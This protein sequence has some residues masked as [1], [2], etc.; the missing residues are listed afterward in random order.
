MS[1]LNGISDVLFGNKFL[2]PGYQRSYS[3][4]VSTE[5][6]EK[7][8]NQ[9]LAD[10]KDF[11]KD[12]KL[13]NYYF[14]HFILKKQENGRFDIVDGQQRLTTITIFLSAALERVK[15]FDLSNGIYGSL[16]DRKF[17]FKLSTV[18]YDDQL[19]QDYV[20]EGRKEAKNSVKTLSQK[21]IVE[22]YDFFLKE[23]QR[24]SDGDVHQLV[25]AV[26][27]ADC[28]S[29]IVENEA[30]AMRMFVFENNRGKKLT[31]LD[32]LKSKL[33]IRISD[34][35][36]LSECEKEDWFKIIIQRFEN[37]YRSLSKFEDYLDED[38]VL[39]YSLNI[40]F[41]KFSATLDNLYKELQGENGVD[42]VREFTTRLQFCCDILEKFFEE[43][44]TN[45]NLQYVIKLSNEDNVL[46][47]FILKSRIS[48]LTFEDE[49]FLNLLNALES[50]FVRSIITG[51]R[52]Y[53][54]SRLSD[55]FSEF[56]P[57][58]VVDKINWMK[59]QRGWYGYWND[60]A[61]SNSLRGYNI[62]RSTS[63]LLLWKYENYLRE[64]D[65]QSSYGKL[66][67]DDIKGPQLEHIAPLTKP[68]EVPQS[69]YGEYDEEF[70]R[71]YLDS[72]GN[73]LLLSAHHN[74]SI[75]N[76]PFDEKR[77]SYSHLYQQREVQE[78]TKNGEYW[79]KKQIA[80]RKN[81]IIKFLLDNY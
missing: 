64:L 81:K 14:G 76:S 62:D 6:K 52:A 74:G 3:W 67:F 29:V 25:A 22:A 13:S 41:N 15:G 70:K 2:V 19:F 7:E 31:N 53:L 69:G 27:N 51:T 49:K 75:G 48:G 11:I 45:V 60:E 26:L 43:F 44:K 8:V 33:I 34:D 68:S 30:E 80:D 66:L 21:R 4:R 12:S 1:N 40:Y 24:I 28:S 77:K 36:K 42:M 46:Y 58:K 10:L 5:G 17:P 59:K 61:F 63:K 32:N 55:V 16:V 37:I 54:Y 38:N 78:M 18:V 73:H 57:V 79:Y 72:I 39:K 47:S 71:D 20:I 9:F 35:T 65:Q 56:N 23:L 50:M